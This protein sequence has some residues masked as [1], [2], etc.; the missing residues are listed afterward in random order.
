MG[1]KFFFIY[2]AIYILTYSAPLYSLSHIEHTTYCVCLPVKVETALHSLRGD[3][4]LITERER[5]RETEKREERV[6]L[7]E[8]EREYRIL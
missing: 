1:I 5:E 6:L 7:Q 3:S 4:Q 2:Y 8:R